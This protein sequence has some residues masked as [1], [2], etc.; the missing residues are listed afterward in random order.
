MPNTL[1]PLAVFLGRAVIV[2]IWVP[3]VLLLWRRDDWPGLL[4]FGLVLWA[5]LAAC[6]PAG[7]D[8]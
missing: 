7:P 4:G 8:R 2:A 6:R 1:A 3:A 5:A